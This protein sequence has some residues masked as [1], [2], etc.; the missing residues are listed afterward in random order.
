M[1]LRAQKKH[2]VRERIL[3]ACARLFRTR[4][5][6]ET[7]ITDI[8]DAAGISRQT[9]FNYFSGKEAVLTE[10]GLAWLRQ[11]AEVPRLR[12][13]R[14]GEDSI[15]A[16]TRKAILTQLK[17]VEH[18]ADLMRLIFTRSGLLFP[19]A[20]PPD[21]GAQRVQAEHTRAI[22][23]AIAGVIRAGQEAGEI[24]RD[25]PALQIAEIYVSVMLMTIR[26]WLIDY[27]QDGVGRARQLRGAAR[28]ARA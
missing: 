17:S 26:L 7:T 22:F 27:W 9:F 28:T 25:V 15:L 19:Q 18:D 23:E 8:I 5:F 21:S 12:S 2:E 20:A 4:G 24:R 6:D 3:A 16:G 11:Q 14:A 13:K 10:L 1:N